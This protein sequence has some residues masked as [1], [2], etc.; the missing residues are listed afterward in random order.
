[1]VDHIRGTLL[2]QGDVRDV[3]VVDGRVSFSTDERVRS[4]LDGCFL[5]PGL[6]DVH[7]HLGLRSPAGDDAPADVAVR[8][9]AGA[10]LRAG[11]LLIREPGS[12]DGGSARF[13]PQEGL[14]RVITAGRFLAPPGGFVPTLALHVEPDELPE[15]AAAEVSSGV[16]WVKIVGDFPAPGG[17]LRAN[18]PPRVL[19]AATARVHLLG[20]RVAIHAMLPEVIEA[21]IEAGVDSIEHGGMVRREHLPAMAAAGVAWVP[22]LVAYEGMF[23]MHRA[24]GAT[25]EVLAPLRDAVAKLPG[26]VRDAAE[27]GVTVLAGTD[28]GIAPHGQILEE[29]S[30]LRLAGLGPGPALGAASW[31]ARSW[32]GL[33]EIEEGAPADLVAYRRNPLEHPEVLAEP[34]LIMLDGRIVLLTVPETEAHPPSR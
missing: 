16:R 32:L 22:T 17:Q 3:F 12:A 19:A 10:H 30:R 1:M 20:G 28:A 21:A 9:S 34:A 18:Y 31:T 4:L 6:V 23:N 33:P 26:I 7:A 25:E 15:T 27:A 8:A 2:P 11:V 13:G 5:I 29:I 14:P 24:L